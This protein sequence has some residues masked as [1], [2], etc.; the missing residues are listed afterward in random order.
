MD[1]LECAI[2]L[3]RTCKLFCVPVQKE[4]QILE[5]EENKKFRGF[6]EVIEMISASQKPIV[7]YSSL[8]GV[9]LIY[10]LFLVDLSAIFSFV[11]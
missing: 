11:L 7:S 3:C 1:L 8:H 4:L 9:Y 5:D 2:Q 6:R 10:S